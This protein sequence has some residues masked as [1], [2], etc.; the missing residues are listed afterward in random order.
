MS[1]VY[2]SPL[3]QKASYSIEKC[4][5]Y[6][7]E[8]NTISNIAIAILLVGVAVAALSLV[9]HPVLL[10]PGM[11]IALAGSGVFVFSFETPRTFVASMPSYFGGFGVS[12]RP[13]RAGYTAYAA[14]SYAA[15]HRGSSSAFV[16]TGGHGGFGV[17]QRR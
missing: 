4:A 11:V 1:S 7:E 14:P 3:V 2:D 10:V 8:T 5:D 17:F 15:P 12:S 16:S 9:L 13:S 6:H